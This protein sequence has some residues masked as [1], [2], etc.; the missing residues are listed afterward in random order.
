MGGG[1]VLG[2]AHGYWVSRREEANERH[3]RIVS[4]GAHGLFF[5]PY[6]PLFVL[7]VLTGR[8]RLCPALRKQAPE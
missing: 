3:R 1:L 5:G 8:H 2:S 7:F 4:H 6:A